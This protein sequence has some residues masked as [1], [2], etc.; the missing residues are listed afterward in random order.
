MIVT[1]DQPPETFPGD[2]T[3]LNHIILPQNAKMDG[4]S[5]AM[6]HD[7]AA[8]AA[9]T[10]TTGR[11]TPHRCLWCSREINQDGPGR[12]RRYCGQ[13][14]RQRAYEQ[15]QSLKGTSIPADALILT[16]S[17]AE[18]LSDRLFEVRCAAED[19]HAAVTDGEPTDSITA[20]CEELVGLARDA[21]SIRGRGE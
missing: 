10:T 13:S 7:S 19:V 14:C 4:M 20:L 9:T 17:T 18:E 1:T 16:R 6:P 5:P 8:A 2:T 3:V 12:R 21:E 11:A 15:R